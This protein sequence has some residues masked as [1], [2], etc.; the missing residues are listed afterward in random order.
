MKRICIAG[1]MFFLISLL[2]QPVK[3]IAQNESDFSAFLKAGEEDASKLM[4]AY[5]EPAVKSMSFGMTGGW[6]N[7]AKPH[8]SLGFDIGVTANL[9]F[10]PTSENYFNPDDLDLS[11]TTF[12]GNTT[13]PGKGA[14]TF[15]GPKDETQYTSTYSYDP[16]G[17]GPLPPVPQSITYSGPEGLDVKDAIGFAATPVPMIQLGIGVIKNTDI[18]IRFVNSGMIGSIIPNVDIENSEFN[19]FGIGVMHDIKQHIKGIKLLPFDLSALVAYNSVSGTTDLSN[20]DTGDARPDSPDGELDYK[21]NSWVLQ[22]LISKKISV[23]TGYAGVG[24]NIV[25][26]TVDVNGEYVIDPN[27]PDF[28]LTDPV[29]ID[30]RNNSLRLTL[31]MRLKFGPV[32]FNGDYTLQKYNTLSLGLGVSVR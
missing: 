18:K 24:Y 13:N 25:N 19:I 32:Y 9:A 29:A 7:T 30:Y 16:D 31:G 21:F 2:A 11:S 8:K 28:V 10:I 26:T 6:Y 5:L 1:I 17:S 3:T 27:N 4:Q 12:D 23:L 15:F 20:T 14:P 22:A